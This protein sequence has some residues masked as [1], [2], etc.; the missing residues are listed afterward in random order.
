MKKAYRGQKKL[1]ELTASVAMPSAQRYGMAMFKIITNW[2]HIVGAELSEHTTPKGLLFQP[3]KTTAGVLQIEVENPGF[4]LELQASESVIVQKIATFFGYQAI[5]KIK[6]SIARTRKPS[7]KTASPIEQR[8]HISQL[9]ENTIRSNIDKI[10]DEELR[11]VL[12]SLAEQSFLV[13]E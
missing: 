4:S 11:R 10:E 13:D 5:D 2:S 12:E 1:G 8:Q 3:G 7:L 6:V 9:H